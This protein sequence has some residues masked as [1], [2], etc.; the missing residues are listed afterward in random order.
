M[1]PSSISFRAG[2]GPERGE[3]R[4]RPG[5]IPSGPV[6][7]KIT[8]PNRTV[9]VAFDGSTWSV[10]E[11]SEACLIEGDDNAGALF[12]TGRIG[13]ADRRLRVSSQSITAQFKS[14]FP[15]P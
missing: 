14:W 8:S 10:S 3:R 9:P 11:A 2:P 13:A 6:V 12:A 1:R 5:A 4:R 15:G 7:D